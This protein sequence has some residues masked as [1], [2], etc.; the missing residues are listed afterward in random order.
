[1]LLVLIK[2]ELWKAKA[3]NDAVIHPP[4]GLRTRATGRDREAQGRL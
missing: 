3:D 2:E 4:H 1:M